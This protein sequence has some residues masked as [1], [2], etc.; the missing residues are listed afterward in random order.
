VLQLNGSWLHIS[1][2]L[3]PSSGQLVQ[4]KYPQFSQEPLSCS[5]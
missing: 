2:A 3:R 5:T 1:T 4:I